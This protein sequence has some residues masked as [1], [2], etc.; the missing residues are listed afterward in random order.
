MFYDNGIPESEFLQIINYLIADGFLDPFYGEVKDPERQKR[1]DLKSEPIQIRLTFSGS[2]F[3]L[4]EGYKA[5]KESEKFEKE[6][7][8]EL[9]RKTERNQSSLVFL[10]GV[11]A[12]GTFVAAFYYIIQLLK[13]CC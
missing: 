3:F 8:S 5:L 9:E 7:I 2:M 4:N 6:R 10:T 1:I 13:D 12:I 11:I